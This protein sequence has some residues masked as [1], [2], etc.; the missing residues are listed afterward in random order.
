MR[1]TFALVAAVASAASVLRMRSAAIHHSAGLGRMSEQWLG[2]DD[3]FAGFGS[4]YSKARMDAW[5]AQ[6]RCPQNDRLCTEAVWLTQTMLLGPRSDMDVIAAAIR[7]IQ[8]SAIAAGRAAPAHQE[9]LQGLL[10]GR[11]RAMPA[12]IS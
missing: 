9:R 7:K 1:V 8:A 5:R 4:I 11:A 10:V 2:L 3:A 12:G 6:N